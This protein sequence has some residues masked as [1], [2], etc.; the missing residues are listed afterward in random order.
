MAP[1]DHT[2]PAA[3]MEKILKK[4]GAVR[5][6]DDAKDALRDVLDEYGVE[7]GKKA[8]RL[9]QHAGRKTLKAVDIK[10]ALED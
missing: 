2:L 8:I 7:V 3:A 5:V 10:A 1:R 9:A 4:A 6:G